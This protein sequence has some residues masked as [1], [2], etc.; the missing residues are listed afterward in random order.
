MIFLPSIEF[1]HEFAVRGTCGVEFVL[2]IGQ[3]LGQI[4]DALLELSHM[5]TYVAGF[6]DCAQSARPDDL[7]TECF[8]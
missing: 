6:I 2:L 8:G 4:S 7:L 3:L 5:A 1:G